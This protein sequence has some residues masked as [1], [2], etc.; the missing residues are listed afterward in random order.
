[1][2]LVPENV[3]LR[4]TLGI[5]RT[6]EEAET[7]RGTKEVRTRNENKNDNEID[8]DTSSTK[9]THLFNIDLCSL[10]IKLNLPFTDSEPILDFV[11]KHSKNIY[12]KDSKLN[13]KTTSYIVKNEIQCYFTKELK[14]KLRSNFYSLVID[15]ATDITKKKFLALIVQYWEKAEGV[16]TRLMGLRECSLDSSA[17]SLFQILEEEIITNDFAK[18]LIGLVTDGAPVMNGANNSVK[19]RLLDAYPY[20]WYLWCPCHCLNLVASE[21]AKELPENIDN[22]VTLIVGTINSPKKIS[23][24]GLLNDESYKKLVKPSKTRWLSNQAANERLLLLW[25]PVRQFLIANKETKLIT[26]M[27]EPETKVYIQF[28]TIFLK[29][30]NITNLIFQNEICEI[31]EMKNTL[32]K[33]Y[34]NF[35]NHIFKTNVIIN[36]QSKILDTQAK[37]DLPIHDDDKIKD[38]LMS[39]ED[40]R[41]HFL[42]VFE[43]SIHLKDLPNDICLRVCKIFKRFILTTLRKFRELLPFDDLVLKHISTLDPD[44]SSSNDWIILAD[45]FPNIIPKNI[46]DKFFDD[47]SNWMMDI[48]KLKKLKSDFIRL[49]KV[50]SSDDGETKEVKR[51]DVMKF[52]MSEDLTEKYPLLATLARALLSLPHSGATVERAFS[53]LTLVKDEKRNRLGNDTLESLMIAKINNHDLDNPEIFEKI[54]EHHES[55]RQSLKRKHSGISASNSSEQFEDEESKELKKVRSFSSTKEEA[56]ERII[57]MPSFPSSTSKIQISL[58]LKVTRRRETIGAT[59]RNSR[60]TKIQGREDGK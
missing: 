29:K 52:Y 51:F 10:L 34:V 47:T 4:L 3:P 22:F 16:V 45:T 8:D 32:I 30:I 25:N 26:I 38:Y 11:K 57:Q 21:A 36:N 54:Y 39:P 35:S 53:Q 19:K 33:T 12:V 27:D 5:Y 49:V 23:E 24:F 44:A 43:A 31:F 17:E 9:K 7:H 18:N 20:L 14:E 41:K 15:E 42:K 50:K 1:L 48:E 2:R 6:L 56:N 13:R 28:L 59:K 37:L 46:F 40:I 60:G 55:W 58:Q